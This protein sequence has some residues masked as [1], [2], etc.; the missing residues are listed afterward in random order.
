MPLII[1]TSTENCLML[2]RKMFKKQKMMFGLNCKGTMWY[3]Q[4]DCWQSGRITIGTRQRGYGKFLKHFI[5]GLVI[6]ADTRIPIAASSSCLY[7]AISRRLPPEQITCTGWLLHMAKKQNSTDYP[8]WWIT[9]TSKAKKICTKRHLNSQILR[10][11]Y[12]SKLFCNASCCVWL[13]SRW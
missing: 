12:T 8:L 10:Q 6:N 4:G 9:H 1:N 7:T 13:S 11:I 5:S 3:C 2:W